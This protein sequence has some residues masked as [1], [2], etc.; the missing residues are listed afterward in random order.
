MNRALFILILFINLSCFSQSQSKMNRDA[1]S[2]YLKAD[3]E[4]NEV[5]K[6]ICAEYK[7]DTIFSKSLIKAQRIWLK[8]RD[9]ELE[10][11][12]PAQDTQLEYGSVYPM[13]ASI[14]LKKIT[15][16][17]IEKLRTWLNGIEEGEVCKGSVK[18]K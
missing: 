10:M 6:K 7:S 13:C 2:E 18:I 3:N 5:Y 14:F 15:N 17:R 12:F 11:R 8:Y 4:L 9:A 1:K 16:E